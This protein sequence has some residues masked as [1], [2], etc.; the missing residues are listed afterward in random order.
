MSKVNYRIFIDGPHAFIEETEF[1]ADNYE[2]FRTYE[3]AKSAI[4]KS[5]TATVKAYQKS[6]KEVQKLKPTNNE[7]NHH[8]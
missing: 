3:R 1:E 4:L 2:I 8:S 7:T 6:I 5:L